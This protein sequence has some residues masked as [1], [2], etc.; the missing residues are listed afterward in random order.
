MDLG[1]IGVWSGRLQRRPTAE[2]RASA[3]DWEQLG[4]GTLW[5]PESPGGKD[6]LT[7]SAILLA[8]TKRIPIATGIAIIWAR[9][10]VAMK[11]ASRTLAEAF[12]DRFLLGVGISHRSTAVLRGHEYA[13]PLAA[14]R[15]YLTAMD[16]APFDGHPPIAEPKK[17]VAALGPK[18]IAL[19]GDLADGVHPFLS[20]PDHTAAAREILGPEKLIAVEQGVVL[21]DDPDIARD[22][23][24][25]NFE[26]FLR[27]P[28]YRNHFRRMGFADKDLSEG[29]SDLLV[30]ALY[31]WGDVGAIKKRVDEHLDAGADHVCLQVVA[32]DLDEDA[33]LRELAPALLV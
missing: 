13:K 4:Y 19:A 18:M 20:T 29:G 30:D 25:T 27:W 12:A 6:V 11:N 31:A 7:F 5:I 26:R 10:P 33:A 8:S 9:D 28:N 1:R 3:Q 14:M 2:A 22:A 16:A 32:G 21:A 24:R 15:A 23:A 17:V